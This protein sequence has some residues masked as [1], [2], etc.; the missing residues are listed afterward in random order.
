MLRTGLSRRLIA[1]VAAYGLALQAML[2][3]VIVAAPGIGFASIICAPGHPSDAGRTRQP[4]APGHGCDCPL[5]PLAGSGAAALPSALPAT[6]RIYAAAA[7]MPPWRAAAPASR[8]V[9]RAGL[10]RAPPA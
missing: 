9:L 4:P 8:M 1:L 3:A 6:I 7:P 5:C 10:A 2:A